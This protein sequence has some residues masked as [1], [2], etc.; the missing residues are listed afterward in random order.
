MTTPTTRS[1]SRM[2]HPTT[3]SW[4]LFGWLAVA[5]LLVPVV[6]VLYPVLM[7]WRER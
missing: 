5:I 2:K 1:V 4:S 6:L 7:M 3:A